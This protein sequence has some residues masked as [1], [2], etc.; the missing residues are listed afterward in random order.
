MRKESYQD[1]TTD[2]ERTV[3]YV[4][5]EVHVPLIAGW[6]RLL[7]DQRFD[8]SLALRHENYSDFGGTTNPKLGVAYS[9]TAAATLRA[10]W[11]K[12]FRA[13]S[14]AELYSNRP[15]YVLPTAS[16]TEGPIANPLVL[17]QSG[18]NPSLRPEISTFW[19]SG[20]SISSPSDP[21]LTASV[22]YFHMRY[23]DRILDPIDILSSALDDPLNSQFILR[24][25]TADFQRQLIGNATSFQNF[26]GM[27]YVP[28]SVEAYI[29]DDSQN[30]TQQNIDGVDVLIGR[31]W[32]SRAGRMGLAV[33]ASWLDIQQRIVPGAPL[34]QVTGTIFNPPKL[35][36]RGGPSWNYRGWSAT[37]TLN[38]THSETDD[39]TDPGTPVG[40]WTTV[41]TQ[42][43]YSVA[44]PTGLLSGLKL[45]VVVL[46]AFDRS[47]PYVN[48]IST[49]LVGLGYDSTNASPLGRV[50]SVYLTKV[51]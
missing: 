33:N 6:S 4:Y 49:S 46:N 50:T 31:K 13:P 39:S 18:S 20:L 44:T 12:S 51:W 48:A 21:G 15:L 2:G 47:P 40:S 43:S 24:S 3:K 35:R 22:T 27:L 29:N 11:G 32:E 25:P 5:A 37:A 45:S 36:I 8:L 9:P 14:L 10:S 34:K 26:S 38:Y 28:E 30:A 16:Y 41:D 42:L 7:P 17:F 23:R 1:N 19:T